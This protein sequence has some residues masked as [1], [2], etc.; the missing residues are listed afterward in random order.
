[1]FAKL[2]VD[3][4]IWA[5]K[6][7]V[8]GDVVHTVVPRKFKPVEEYLKEQG[9]FVHLFKPVRQEEIL[10]KIQARVDQYWVEVQGKESIKK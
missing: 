1:M 9:R 5:L 6:E 3:T 2:A 4:G 7:A 10:A 8:Y